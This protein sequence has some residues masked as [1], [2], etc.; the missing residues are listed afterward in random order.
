VCDTHYAIVLER[1]SAH[2]IPLLSSV[3]EFGEPTSRFSFSWK[4]EVFF[5]PAEGKGARQLLPDDSIAQDANRLLNARLT[6]RSG[7]DRLELHRIRALLIPPGG[8]LSWDSQS[9]GALGESLH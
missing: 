6:W 4:D 3:G 9:H 5:D 2:A 8:P 1:A 7:D